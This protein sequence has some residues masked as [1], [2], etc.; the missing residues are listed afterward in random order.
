VPGI[1]ERAG[2]VP[3]IVGGRAKPATTIEWVVYQGLNARL[4]TH[5]SA[6]P[7]NIRSHRTRL[8]KGRGVRQASEYG[9]FDDIGS[10]DFLDERTVTR[11]CPR[12]GGTRLRKMLHDLSVKLSLIDLLPHALLHLARHV[13]VVHDGAA[14]AQAT[15]LSLHHQHPE[16][17]AGLDHQG[18]PCL[19]R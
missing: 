19:L 17:A 11:S 12:G 16:R 4:C 8:V 1:H 15:R 7:T 5:K 10:V 2:H 9:S 3:R 6:G 13:I 14:V 18:T